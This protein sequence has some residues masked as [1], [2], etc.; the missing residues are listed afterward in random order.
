MSYITINIK[1]HNNRLI[2]S[3]NDLVVINYQFKHKVNKIDSAK[4]FSLTN[5]NKF[6]DLLNPKS[7]N[8]KL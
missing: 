1:L 2:I 7:N 4:I 3:A 8:K 5:D 6:V